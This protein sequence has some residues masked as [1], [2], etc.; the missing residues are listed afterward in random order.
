[1]RTSPTIEAFIPEQFPGEYE[2]PQ[3]A[4]YND[5]VRTRA[6]ER[7]AIDN[8][9][10][11]VFG[12]K[13][14]GWQNTHD[15]PRVAQVLAYGTAGLAD[16]ADRHI[17]AAANEANGTLVLAE[18]TGARVAAEATA[19]GL[20]RAMT[21]EP[22]DPEDLDSFTSTEGKVNWAF[23][24][25]IPEVFTKVQTELGRKI[26]DAQTNAL[27][28]QIDGNKLVYRGDRPLYVYNEFSG[29]RPLAPKDANTHNMHK[30]EAG[31]NLVIMTG[32]HEL[33]DSLTLQ[34]GQTVRRIMA[35]PTQ[36]RSAL[37]ATRIAERL[38]AEFSTDKPAGPIMVSMVKVKAAA[39]PQP[40]KAP[41]RHVKWWSPQDLANFALVKM[42]TREPAPSGAP[43]STN[44]SAKRHNR[45]T[46]RKLVAGASVAGIAGLGYMLVRE[47]LS[48]TGKAELPHLGALIPHTP[49][50]SDHQLFSEI[51]KPNVP[52]THK[53][54]GGTVTTPASHPFITS[55]MA[56]AHDAANGGHASNIT[57]ISRQA[58]EY[59]GHAAGLSNAKINGLSHD[60]TIIN[61]LNQAFMHDSHNSHNVLALHDKHHFLYA[62]DSYSTHDQAALAKKIVASHAHT[63]TTP[64]ANTKTGT[65]PPVSHLPGNP[66]VKIG[67]PRPLRA[68]DHVS[69]STELSKANPIL[70]TVAALGAAAVGILGIRAG[71]RQSLRRKQIDAR[72][73]LTPEGNLLYPLHG[74]LKR[75]RELAQTGLLTPNM[76]NSSSSD[77]S[78]REIVRVPAARRGM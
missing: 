59:Y 8:A 11:G 58:L 32:T 60:Q 12:Y 72:N 67:T 51:P 35:E 52:I 68:G 30:L 56:R 78:T 43:A 14:H 3:Q 22:K 31:R 7:E 50:L 45:L 54:G 48:A 40:E 55:Y 13:K 27:A 20:T 41:S 53:T 37:E 73:N 75:Y 28:V 9:L 34:I 77:A 69:G 66:L 39:A 76:L 17:A 26:E 1:M 4:R 18:S 49:H 62:G 42:M 71:R 19:R 47:A 6:A 2:E 70:T 21:A 15:T 61:Q 10:T 16:W 24:K 29:I 46:S 23:E 36:K 63:H 64:P 74:K 25:K 33:N 5:E 38:H 57:N 65:L 44:T